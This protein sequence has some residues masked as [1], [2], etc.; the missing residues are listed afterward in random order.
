MESAVAL[1][2]LSALLVANA[3]ATYVVVRDAYVERHQRIFQIAVVWLLPVLGAIFIFALHR[4]PEK[5]TGKYREPPNIGDDF[6]SPRHMGR[7]IHSQ[8]DDSHGI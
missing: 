7:S 3:W 1:T 4:K 5:P 6:A 8:A 2:L